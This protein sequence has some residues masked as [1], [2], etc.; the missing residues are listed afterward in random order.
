M[1]RSRKRQAGE[2][3]KVEEYLEEWFDQK[4]AMTKK[5]KQYGIMNTNAN[6]KLKQIGYCGACLPCL[7]SESEDIV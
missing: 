7:L 2:K 3:S 1:K 4:G 5:N 6:S